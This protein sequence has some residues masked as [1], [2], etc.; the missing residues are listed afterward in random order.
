MAVCTTGQHWYQG[1]KLR[2]HALLE[3]LATDGVPHNRTSLV[4][5]TQAMDRGTVRNIGN[6][7]QYAQQ[8]NTDQKLNLRTQNYF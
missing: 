6:R 3:I 5:G 4:S 8:Y 2:T 1:H 7:L